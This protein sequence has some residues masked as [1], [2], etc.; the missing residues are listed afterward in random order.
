MKGASRANWQMGNF[1]EALID[2]G[3]TDLG[4]R[5]FLFT[6]CNNRDAPYTVREKLGLHEPDLDQSIPA[7][8]RTPF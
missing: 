8:I 7:L 3:L 1:R 2:T 4:F 6:W 5:G